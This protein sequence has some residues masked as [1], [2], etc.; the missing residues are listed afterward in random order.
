[1][2]RAISGMGKWSGIWTILGVAIGLLVASAAGVF[3][4]PDNWLQAQRYKLIRA[5]IQSN[6][7]VVAIDSK[8]L[9]EIGQWPWPR[10]IH[11]QI[12]ERLVAAR[13]GQIAMD[14]DFSS[15]SSEAGDED[16]YRALKAAGGST[17]LAGFKQS[18][19]QAQVDTV[20]L[21]RFAEQAWIASVSV[22]V[23]Q[24]GIVRRVPFSETLAGTNT[25]SLAAY[26]AQV[27]GSALADINIDFSISGSSF[28]LISA[29]DLLQGK[30]PQEM[31]AGK[32]I[33]V[34]ATAVELRDLFITPTGEIVPGGV[35]QAMAAETA[36]H[37]RSVLTP[38]IS[39]QGLG[40]FVIALIGVAA[41]RRPLRRQITAYAV[42]VDLVELAAFTLQ[43]KQQIAMPTTGWVIALVCLAAIATFSELDLRKLRLGKVQT[44]LGATKALLHEVIADSPAGVVVVDESNTVRVANLTARQILGIGEHEL[45][46][47]PVTEALPVQLAQ[48]FGIAGHPTAQQ[49]GQL[50]LS[51]SHIT[52]LL[53]YSLTRS[54]VANDDDGSASA[55]AI[56]LTFQD[57]TE[58]QEQLQRLS[59]LALHDPLTDTRNRNSFV[60]CLE[61][62][63][64]NEQA[65]AVVHVGLDKFK[66]INEDFG[67]T[68]GDRLLAHFAS[69]A[70][71]Q[72]AGHGHFYRIAGDEFACVLTGST[73]VATA[74]EMAQMLLHLGGTA[75]LEPYE[76]RFSVSVGIATADAGECE[77]NE[78]IRRS[79]IALASAKA[80]G[81]N[82]MCV[83]NIELDDAAS[84]RKALETAL[85]G[86]LKRDEFNLL[87]STAV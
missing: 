65:F 41:S 15:A 5:P 20:P 64:T 67:H 27:D 48:L 76:I 32:D 25:P 61:Q 44:R 54:T 57:V 14:I 78:I 77:A 42:L 36:R 38:A 17:I 37:N 7:V 16:F 31:I 30:V 33:I 46:G 83:F 86:A 4:S 35:L 9:A 58:R 19:G 34:G 60:E 21:S 70:K 23:D 2:G 59:Y 72:L 13:A 69:Q 80:K 28:A 1:M 68:A 84:R 53:E 10:S 66:Y 52:K 63:V 82:G 74:T 49:Q 18:D 22:K 29:T 26:L 81:G 3:T 6:I 45:V 73:N 47:L 75:M 50:A 55:S 79:E 8:S 39:F 24:D 40:L 56:C 11:A 71:M 62:L 85:A 87:Y 43:W 12:I 51:S